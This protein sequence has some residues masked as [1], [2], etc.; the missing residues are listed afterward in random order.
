VAAETALLNSTY[1]AKRTSKLMRMLSAIGVHDAMKSR[2]SCG[3]HVFDGAVDLC[4]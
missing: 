1:S 3:N 4:E 2:V